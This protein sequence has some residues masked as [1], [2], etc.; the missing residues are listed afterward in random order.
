[1]PNN[2]NKAI[3]YHPVHPARK[4]LFLAMQ[5][6]VRKIY[7]TQHEDLFF[8]WIALSLCAGTKSSFGLILPEV[9]RNFINMFRTLGCKKTYT[10]G[11]VIRVNL[12]QRSTTLKSDLFRCFSTTYVVHKM[13][14]GTASNKTKQPNKYPTILIVFL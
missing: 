12:V 3:L 13:I 2:L 8:Q 14:F 10:R 4:S 11:S 9:G 1:M 6:T 7:F 5:A